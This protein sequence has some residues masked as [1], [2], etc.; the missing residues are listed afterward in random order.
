[1]QIRHHYIRELDTLT[2]YPLVFLTLIIKDITYSP[3]KTQIL[4]YYTILWCIQE[5]FIRTL[6]FGQRGEGTVDRQRLHVRTCQIQTQ[7]Y[8]PAHSSQGALAMTHGE[9]TS[10]SAP[11]P[12]QEEG[13]NQHRI[14]AL[15]YH[16]YEWMTKQL[17]SRAA[18]IA[19]SHNHYLWDQVLLIHTA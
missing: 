15:L 11:S 16:R 17:L 5:L 8:I 18:R 7:P 1:M 9:V 6:V 4:L 14:S 2:M 12:L 3:Y 19:L 10:F 13:Q